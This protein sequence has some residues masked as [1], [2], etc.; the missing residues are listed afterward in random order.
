MG[1]IRHVL[2]CGFKSLSRL[3]VQKLDQVVCTAFLHPLNY[4]L[5]LELNHKP[6]VLIAGLKSNQSNSQLKHLILIFS[7]YNQ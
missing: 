7:S 3:T 1:N 2:D 4:P 5:W 6:N